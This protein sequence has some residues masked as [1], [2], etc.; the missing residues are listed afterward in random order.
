MPSPSDSSPA[1]RVLIVGLLSGLALALN[2]L[3]GG[4]PLPAPGVKPGLANAVSLMALLLYGPRIAWS[5]LAVRLLLAGLFSGN[6]FAFGCSVSG[7][8]AAMTVMMGLQRLFGRDITAWALSAAGA[9]THNGA[10]LLFVIALVG[11]RALL[12]YLP[13]LILSGLASG[14]A[15][16][17]IAG[18]AAKR[19]EGIRGERNG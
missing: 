1:G 18:W 2:L 3:E 6:L 9:V 7:G 17:L 13:L 16:G 4:L 12:A 19:L 8:I 11:S 5:V 10:Q 15:V 14:L